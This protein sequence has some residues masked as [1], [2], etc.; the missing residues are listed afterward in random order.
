[1]SDVTL[2]LNLE[3]LSDV[4]RQ[5]DIKE[6]KERVQ[7]V[8]KQVKDTNKT[9]E[10]M[11]DD[12]NQMKMTDKE[13]ELFHIARENIFAGKI[14]RLRDGTLTKAE[15]M[16][17]GRQVK[18]RE[19]ENARAE[20][21]EAVLQNKPDNFFI[22]T[23]DSELPRFIQRVREEC[24]L[25]RKKWPGRWDSIGV[26]SLMAADYEGTG[27][28]SY[29]DLSIGFSIWLPLLDEGYYLAYGH[30]DGIDEVN[31]VKIPTKYQHNGTQLTRSK[32]IKALKPYLEA[33]T[34]GKSFHMG[35][36][37]YDLHVAMKD[38]IEIRGLH[39]DS[40]DA[41]YMMFEHE[42][43]YALKKLVQKYGNRFGID[44]TKVFTFEDLFGNC[45]PAP[46]SIELVGIYAILDVL[47]GWKLTEWQ[48]ETMKKTNRLL[49]CYTEIDSRLPETDVM[50]TR[51]GFDIDLDRM[52]QLEEEFTAKLEQAKEDLFTTYNIDKKFLADMSMKINGDKIN[53]WVQK[54]EKRI[55]TYNERINKQ[56]DIIEDCKAN[57]KTNLKKYKNASEMY[58]KYKENPPVDAIPENSPHWIEEFMLT[59][60]NHIGYLIYDFL[61]IPD[62]TPR[63]KRGKARA[64]SKDVLESYFKDHP[65]LEPLKTV[66]ELEKL[67]GTYVRKIPQALEIDGKLH[68]T[69]NATGT[70]TGRY[71]SSAYGGRPVEVYKELVQEFGEGDAE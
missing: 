14:E 55:E 37:R 23:N 57:G 34:E 18:E 26:E 32:V 2:T 4:T 65:E 45:S 6:Q 64:T 59:N 63:F 15:V 11:I 31:G 38:G 27:V 61:G 12:V 67:L 17:I 20:R 41:M 56:K 43:S 22:L 54:Q 10:E 69:F 29:I 53:D 24:V 48:F 1:M 71:S 68:A 70:G 8:N 66:S 42:P 44:T 25:Q 40:L 58:Q 28:D 35:A 33:E 47:Y 9:L 49:E 52:K 16:E 39:W 3:R 62:A 19:E 7:R 36:T 5:G 21:I 60:N 46:F 51:Q 13:R 50:L 30:V